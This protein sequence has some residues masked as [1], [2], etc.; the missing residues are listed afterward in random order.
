VTPES[1][2][3]G[4]CPITGTAP[5]GRPRASSHWV[6]SAI[7]RDFSIWRLLKSFD[8]C[9]SIVALGMRMLRRI[10]GDSIS[11]PSVPAIGDIVFR[12]APSR[13]KFAR[14]PMTIF[15]LPGLRLSDLEDDR[16]FYKEAGFDTE[17]IAQTDGLY[18]LR[19]TLAEDG[20]I[21]PCVNSEPEGSN[22]SEAADRLKSTRLRIEPR[23]P[24][25]T[26][27]GLNVNAGALSLEISVDPRYTVELGFAPARD[28]D[29][30]GTR[31][32]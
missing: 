10:P 4:D 14:K 5:A 27:E 22:V 1:Q 2:D 29:G 26:I 3:D 9:A 15:E 11:G 6:S 17:I 28:G 25:R 18:T 20:A 13:A 24:S 19:L 16:T 21:L 12:E 32:S 30:R 31:E 8:L 23:N 7:A